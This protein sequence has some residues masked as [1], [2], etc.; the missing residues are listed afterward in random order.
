MAQ[1]AYLHIF[2]F[3]SPYLRSRMV[4]MVLG[5]ALWNTY[6]VGLCEGIYRFSAM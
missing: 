5:V 3:A 4:E 2:V 1:F 6:G